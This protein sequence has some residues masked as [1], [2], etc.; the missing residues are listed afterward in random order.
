MNDGSEEEPYSFYEGWGLSRKI[1]EEL[2]HSWKIKWLRWPASWSAWLIMVGGF[3]VG[4]LWLWPFGEHI[5]HQFAER[6]AAEI[7]AVLLDLNFGWG[8][9][10][11]MVAWITLSATLAGLI[12]RLLPA[13]YK[14]TFFLGLIDDS[15][16][17]HFSQKALTRAL[18]GTPNY[19][20]ASDLAN[21]WSEKFMPETSKYAVPLMLIGAILFL[22]DINRYG[23][24]TADAYHRSSWLPWANG[25][26]I[27]WSEA[28]RVQIGCNQTDDG[29]SLVYKVWFQN[30]ETIRIEDSIPSRHYSWL[31]GIETVDR[32]ISNNGAEFQRWS[33][34]NRNPLHPRCIR[35]YYTHLEDDEHDRF[36]QIL[37]IGQ[38]SQDN[39]NE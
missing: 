13:P 5:N 21:A 17:R 25:A 7:D 18:E 19:H 16:L 33:W 10:V 14:T 1:N 23:A 36:R 3:A 37:R 8:L 32:A 24:Y 30:G 20:S 11:C 31:D 2:S 34:L 35:E 38:F 29:S 9:V 28:E 39:P 15:N 6:K 22:S 27:G 12:C 4:W 26:V